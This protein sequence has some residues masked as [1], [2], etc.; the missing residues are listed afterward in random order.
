MIFLTSIYIDYKWAY[1]IGGGSLEMD[2]YSEI[3]FALGRLLLSVV[4]G[5]GSS[6]SYCPC[7]LKFRTKCE[8][9]DSARKSNSKFGLT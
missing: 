6:D 3:L 5:L 1:A 4:Q 2:S 8:K 7:L 9:R